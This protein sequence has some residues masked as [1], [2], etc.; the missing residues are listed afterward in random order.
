M[1]EWDWLLNVTCYDIS[2][3]YV[4]THRCEGGLKKFDLRSGSQRHIHFVGFF[5]VPVQAPTRGQPFYT[6]YSEKPPHLVAFYDTLGI[7]RTH[8]RLKPRV[9]TAY[10][11][12]LTT[13]FMRFKSRDPVICIFITW[14]RDYDSKAIDRF[15]NK[16]KKYEVFLAIRI[17]R[18]RYGSWISSTCPC[19][20]K[21]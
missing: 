1:S 15:Y 6:V 2:V 3:I 13:L 12:I 14:S 17:P 10:G 9:T 20:V 21:F 7:R 5:N 18:N 4:T 19:P 8:S 11:E 16:N